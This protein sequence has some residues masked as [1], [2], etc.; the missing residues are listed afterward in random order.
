MTTLQKL[1]LLGLALVA[2]CTEPDDTLFVRPML[3][4]VE[5]APGLFRATWNPGPDVTR[6]FTPDGRVVY[7]AHGLTGVDSAWALLSIGL[8]DG[9]VREEA[10]IYR[11]ALR[12]T[13][14]HLRF[15]PSGRL[16]VS[17]RSITESGFDCTGQCPAPAAPVFVT[18]RRL[19][20]TDGAPLSALPAHGIALP[21]LEESST[22]C[23]DTRL[24]LR[25][26]EQE[27]LDRRANPYGPV[28][29]VDGSA[30][31]L[32]DGET[33]WRYVPGDLGAPPDSLGPGAFPALSP[34]GQ[35]LAAAIPLGLDSSS[36][37]C[38]A[39][40][41]PCHMQTVTISSTGW[42]VLLYDLANRAQAPVGPG[43][44]P[45]FDPLAPRLVV[46]RPDG[47]YWVDIATGS[48]TAIPQTE[49]GYAPAVAPDGTV[50]AFTAQRFGNPDIFY[51]RIR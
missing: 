21:S 38:F 4:P 37:E 12:D 18:V 45:A 26:A 6:G 34:D 40:L 25:P 3:P 19:P 43:L 23:M 28:E 42:D 41:C 47:L 30:G 20:P 5:I 48:A 7:L 13:V 49:G 9:A 32:S 22:T 29:L 44:E 11:L 36:A 1:A 35:R 39:G 10:R 31:F 46:R 2:G 50:L 17:W 33:L 15:G 51:V 14:A 27:A 16:L 24:R 8:A